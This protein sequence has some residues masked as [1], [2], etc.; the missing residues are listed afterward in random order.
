MTTNDNNIGNQEDREA[1]EEDVDS[2]I[3]EA[4]TNGG[5]PIALEEQLDTGSKSWGDVQ[6]D[7]HQYS[8]QSAFPACTPARTSFYA[9]EARN[10][11]LFD[12]LFPLQHGGG[13]TYEGWD[14]QRIRSEDREDYRRSHAIL[15]Q[16]DV[17]NPIKK[18]T[19]KR[20]MRENLT[21]FSRYYK[22]L[23][24]AALGFATLYKFDDM[25]IAKDSYLTDEAEEILE[26]DGKMLVDY[27]WR[28]YGDG[29]R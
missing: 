28:K 18:W 22:G 24:G 19:V 13:H 10:P 4:V 5:Q 20:V 17:T 9:R 29:V 26:I 2:E 8:S 7:K 6:K 21:G 3:L 23:D 15:S 27:V 25:E 12:R 16:V 14:G 1:S 11:R